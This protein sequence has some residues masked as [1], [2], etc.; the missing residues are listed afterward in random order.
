[1][2]YVDFDKVR[3]W[4]AREQEKWYFKMQDWDVDSLPSDSSRRKDVITFKI[5]DAE[6]AQ[7]EKDR[8]ESAS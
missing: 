6:T 4:D 5:K 1:M 3:Y 8:I 2:G 7:I